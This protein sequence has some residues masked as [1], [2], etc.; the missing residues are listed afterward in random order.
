MQELRRFLGLASYYRRF[1]THFAR[2][3]HPIYQLTCKGTEFVWSPECKTAFKQLKDRLV[4]NPVLAYPS[5]DEFILETDA[6][7]AGLG[8]VLS[9]CQADGLPHP[10]AY[11]SCALSPSE[12]NYGLLT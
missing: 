11:A 7:A 10:I 1:V 6:S 8:A 9:Q 4:N 12:R 2:I 3:V 5:F